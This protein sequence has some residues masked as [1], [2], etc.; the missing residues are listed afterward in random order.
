M[1]FVRLLIAVVLLPLAAVMAYEFFKV[2]LGVGSTASIKTAPFWAGLLVYFVFQAVFFRP[3]K[4]YVFGHE[5]TH[6]LFALLSGAGMTKFK[7]SS[8]GGSVEL[9][10]SNVWITL[11]P[12]FVPIYTAILVVAYWLA[13][14]F[15][16]VNGL[17]PYFMFGVGFTLSFHLCLTQFALKQGQSDLEKFGVF[18]SS[19]FILIIN[20]VFLV[21]LLKV[22]FPESVNLNLYFKNIVYE[23]AG[24]WKILY[25][26]GRELCYFLKTK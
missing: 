10:K 20:C 22:L 11:A 12:Y 21:V 7:D 26:K 9:T 25:I 3:L 17:Y 16:P 2:V 1:R 8:S 14:V 15:Y 24:A 6:A 5:L 13:G 4:T 18:F 19:V 23:T